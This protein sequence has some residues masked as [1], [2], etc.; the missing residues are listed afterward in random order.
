M[1]VYGAGLPAT[2]G[3]AIDGANVN[4]SGGVT[5]TAVVDS[6]GN[7]LVDGG[8]S[9]GATVR[10]AGNILDATADVALKNLVKRVEKLSVRGKVQFRLPTKVIVAKFDKLEAEATAEAGDVR[11]TIK[12]IDLG[13]ESS[14]S[15]TFGGVDPSK[16]QLVGYDADNKTING[17][18]NASSGFNMESSIGSQFMGQL[19]SLE[20]RVTEE[21]S[22][23]SYEF[24]I[25]DIP[26]RMF[27][28]M[29]Q[30][31]EPLKFEGVAPVTFEF[32]KFDGDDD[33]QKVIVKATNHTNKPLEGLEMKLAYL[34]ANAKTI[35]DMPYSHYE[36][37][38][39]V[40]DAGKTTELEL[41]CF[42]PEG[43]KSAKVT[44]E[45]LRCFDATSWKHD[46]E[47]FPATP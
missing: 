13:Q 38:E 14:V 35:M 32:V 18:G 10:S 43:T 6:E 24:A 34:D 28:E 27:A 3:A 22:A 39:P 16:V 9:H 36:G 26:L 11:F 41:S 21:S 23:V 45:G 40:V 5:L 33:Q 29:P 15:V 44:I 20:I 12:E 25:Q 4:G 1:R 8:P 42:M 46:G 17:Y 37:T 2:A 31:I 47:V 7:G 30:Q 19:A